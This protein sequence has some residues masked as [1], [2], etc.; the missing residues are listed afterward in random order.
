MNKIDYN[1]NLNW[2]HYLTRPFTLFGCSVW[3]TWYA[4]QITK[5]TKTDISDVLFIEESENLARHYR[6][7]EQFNIFKKAIDELVKDSKKCKELLE[8]GDNY[9]KKAL[10]A[11][12]KGE[13]AFSDID[14]AIKFFTEYALHCIIIPAFVLQSLER[15]N[16]YSPMLRELSE[17]LRAKSH[18]PE[19]FAK[20]M[21]PLAINHLK[22][23][24]INL[25]EKEV[26]LLTLS[27]IKSF[28]SSNLEK[29]KN[30][31]KVEKTFIYSIIN[32]KESISWTNNPEKIISKIEKSKDSSQSLSGRTAF[33]GLVKGKARVVTSLEGSEANFNK[34]DILV[35]INSNPRLISLI[36][37]ASAIIAEEGSV[38]CHAAIISREMK[39]PCV[40]GVKNATKLIKSGSSIEVDANKGIIRIL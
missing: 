25:N 34:G 23:K 5:L 19:L 24:N 36:R 32:G 31:R 11:I 7:E 6:I 35:T 33:P 9:N 14:A 2:T 4:E 3:H 18:Y 10:L 38:S 20:V 28:D 1:E 17:N 15:L 12:K 30:E 39:I 13:K 26:S 40:M 37:K 27:E 16:I 29:R 22:L 21:I 8:E